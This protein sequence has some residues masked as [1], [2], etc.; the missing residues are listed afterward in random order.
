MSSNNRP[1]MLGLWE[2]GALVAATLTI[3]S[4]RGAPAPV[5]LD[6][7][8]GDRPAF[9]LLP[10]PAGVHIVQQSIEQ[11][12]GRF[13]EAEHLALAVPAGSS[14]PLGYPLPLA[15]VV[16]E[17]QLEAW[18]WCSRPGMQL[19]AMVV[20]PRSTDPKTGQP[21]Q[22]LVRS[23]AP[24]DG[25]E[26]QQLTLGNIPVELERAARV[27]RAAGAS[28]VDARE[29]YVSHLVILAPGGA[30]VTEVWVDQITMHGPLRPTDGDGPL[31]TVD[32]AAQWAGTE[33]VAAARANAAAQRIRPA[34]PRIIQWQGEPLELLARIGFD[35]VWMGRLPRAEEL[36]EA[37]R[38]GLWLVCPPPSLEALAAHGLGDDFTAV[39]AW[40]LGELAVADDVSRLE[41]WSRA[42]ARCDADASRPTLLRPG[43]MPREAS[44]IADALVL[45]RP[46]V[47]ATRSWLEY[48][49]W[50]KQQRR[51]ARTG[52][53]VWIAVD[54]HPSNSVLAQLAAL[55]G[56]RLAPPAASYQ[57]LSQ[58]T[59]AA[60]GVWP[61]GFLFLSESSLAATDPETRMRCLALELTNLR[62]GMVEPWLAG[63]KAAAPARSSRPDFTAMVLTVERS[64]LVAPM[65]WDDASQQ[66]AGIVAGSRSQQPTSLLLPGVPESCDAYVL[67]TAG[68]TRVA[69][70]RVTGGLSMTFQ[71]LPEDAFVLLTEDGFAFSHVE[72]YLRR[73]A[74]RAGQARVELAALRREQAARSMGRLSPAILQRVGADGELARVDAALAAIGRTLQGQDY[75]AAFAR[76]AE[77]EQA[78]DGL[79]QRV[80]AALW[81]DGEPGSSPLPA[82]W[83]ALPELAR[84][85]AATAGS[86]SA[87][88]LLP[89]GD[90]E[91]LP[92]LLDAGWRRSE[93]SPPGVE[94]AVRLSPDSPHDGGYCL[95][96]EARMTA[97]GETAPALAAPPVWVTSPPL[98]VPPGSVVEITGWV[99][100][101]EQPMGSA[102]PVLV[103][104]S[105]GGEE[106]AL[107]I[108]A[109]P[110]WRPFRI[111]R[112]APPGAAC[113]VTIALGGVGR[114]TIDS[115]HY[116]FVP[117]PA[118]PVA[119][120]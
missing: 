74:P 84:V 89:G 99:R 72:R 96:L 101:A 118:G 114:A 37:N 18:A 20:L 77:V 23:D 49:T 59:V 3:S 82:D 16:P 38:L 22:L 41:D 47:G 94:G 51:L 90:F 27:A 93:R 88:A 28:D 43:A 45:S 9:R 109:A 4:A 11:G 39:L 75:A 108:A 36:A 14:A 78:L 7:M 64:H 97:G 87:P 35:A 40:D 58:A 86:S 2:L 19:A 61:R 29:A 62:L 6:D 76:A 33:S 105:L 120:R 67:S 56:A 12:D 60:M 100:V 83:L 31:P 17:L 32:L 79:E 95:E 52:A 57:H 116:R 50:L 111:V 53:D 69:T 30:G 8:N 113:R 103:F 66:A 106:S 110:S 24:V 46:T 80:Y 70:R 107:R 44:R 104:D 10:A 115:L 25:G 92:A 63:G 15:P 112:A 48:S 98:V 26:W 55:G 42:L 81:P 117:L 1:K 91:D 71:Q 21:W 5:L 54:T 65:R 73:Y 13:S 34:L 85:A 68:P 119:L 102:D